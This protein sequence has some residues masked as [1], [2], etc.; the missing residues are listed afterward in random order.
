MNYLLR[1]II[2]SVSV[3]EFLSKKN[4]LL[5][6]TAHYRDFQLDLDQSSPSV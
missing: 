5:R 1:I 3:I 6:I 2:V 4:W